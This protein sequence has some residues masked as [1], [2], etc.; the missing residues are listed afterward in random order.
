MSNEKKQVTQL[1]KAHEGHQ[2]SDKALKGE[3]IKSK[4]DNALNEQQKARD[5][6]KSFKLTKDGQESCMI[7]GLTDKTGKQVI[8]KDERPLRQDEMTTPRDAAPKDAALKE[9][10]YTSMADGLRPQQHDHATD[11]HSAPTA[12]QAIERQSPHQDSKPHD[13]MFRV[14]TES[15]D[16]VQKNGDRV[17]VTT[18]HNADGSASE[19]SVKPNGDKEVVQRDSHGRETERVKS[20]KPR[21]GENSVDE[22]IVTNYDEKTGSP[23]TTATKYDMVGRESEKT[24]SD[25]MGNSHSEKYRYDKD[26]SKHVS[27]TTVVDAFDAKTVHAKYDEQDRKVSQDTSYKNGQTTDH[28]TWAYGPAGIVLH[29]KNGRID[30]GSDGQWRPGKTPDVILPGKDPDVIL[31]SKNPDVILPGKA[32]TDS[33]PFPPPGWPHGGDGLSIKP[34]PTETESHQVMRTDGTFDQVT[35]S[36]NNDGSTYQKTTHPDGSTESVSKD[37]QGRETER[38]KTHNAPLGEVIDE[39]VQ[40]SYNKQTGWPEATTTHYD[41]SG[42]ETER[43]KEDAFGNRHTEKY[44]YDAHNKQYV[45]SLCHF[46]IKFPS[47]KRAS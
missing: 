36:K 12:S 25:V 47:L 7:V 4:D 3:T 19:T 21:F 33:V 11:R 45:R 23:K 40:T 34:V 46:T 38:V 15:H 35:S 10:A 16:V 27:E 24:T 28:E 8:V 37:S 17:N 22:Q 5:A 18:T 32:P 30:N 44:Q 41:M 6:V 14:T 26:N 42:R 39:R 43:V 31:P 13:G 1:D 20:H 29:E 9:T 2:P